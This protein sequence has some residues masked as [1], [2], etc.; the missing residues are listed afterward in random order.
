MSNALPQWCWK[1]VLSCKQN[2][3]L[4]SPCHVFISP[5][6]HSRWFHQ[7]RFFP[8]QKLGRVMHSTA[9]HEKVGAKKK[10]HHKKEIYV[11]WWYFSRTCE[12][13][14]EKSSTQRTRR[15]RKI[16]F[17]ASEK[18]WWKERNSFHL[19][20]TPARRILW[21]SFNTG[22]ELFS[23]ASSATPVLL[24]ID[25]CIFLFFHFMIHL[26]FST[27]FAFFSFLLFCAMWR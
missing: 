3:D 27:I 17:R 2:P 14:E 6:K 20:N 15:W 16:I 19:K 11:M 24:F 9:E 22:A 7:K 4:I 8:P 23:F 18:L 10:H 1:P 21:D 12:R 5:P 25:G 26:E 13:M